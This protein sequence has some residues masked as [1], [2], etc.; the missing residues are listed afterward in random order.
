MTCER[1]IGPHLF[2]NDNRRTVTLTGNSYRKYI[3]KYLLLEMENPDMH[4]M[5]FKQDGAP[6]DTAR[7]T[8]EIIKTVF[9]IRLISCFGD[10]PYRH[11]DPLI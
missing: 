3:L 6:A 7:V 8:I 11:L 9:Q 2:E 1:I 10:V 4:G 5:W